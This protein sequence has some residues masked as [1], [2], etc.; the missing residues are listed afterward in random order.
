MRSVAPP[1]ASRPN[2]S[3]IAFRTLKPPFSKLQVKPVAATRQCGAFDIG[4]RELQSVARTA[5]HVI[6]KR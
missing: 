5:T 2:C 6:R 4:K 3:P 1:I